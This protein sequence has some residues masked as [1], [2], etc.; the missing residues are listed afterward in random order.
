MKDLEDIKIIELFNLRDEQSLSEISLK[1]AE[2]AKSIAYNIL[3]SVEDAEECVND[4]L[5]RLWNN[6][7][8]QQPDNLQAYFYK[9]VRNISIDRYRKNSAEKRADSNM[10]LA[11]DEI[12][13]LIKSDQS[14]ENSIEEK[15]LVQ[16]VNSFLK[17]VKCEQRKIFVQRYWYFMSVKEISSLLNISQSKVTVTL[18]RM[19]KKLWQYLKKEEII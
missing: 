11:L 6:I 12:S 1:Y 16:S 5:V 15:L 13:E 17:T 3:G 4:A 18:T 14:V 10:T 8:P 19:L 9:T 2:K 7:P